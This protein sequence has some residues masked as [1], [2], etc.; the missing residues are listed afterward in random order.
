MPK[1][2]TFTNEGENSDSFRNLHFITLE[3]DHFLALIYVDIPNVTNIVLPDWDYRFI[4]IT[5]NSRFFS[6]LLTNRHWRSVR[7][8]LITSFFQTQ[9]HDKLK[10]SVPIFTHHPPHIPALL[11]QIVGILLPTLFRTLATN[12][13][14]QNAMKYL[15]VTGGVVSGLGKGISI[16]SLGVLLQ[17][18]G[19]KV[20]SIKIDPYLVCSPSWSHCHRTVM[21]VR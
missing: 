18:R 1:L 17:S 4:H 3:S 19:I 2:T 10:H 7:L 15:I 21:R 20:T 6:P 12:N 14:Y 11:S 9:L 8:L 16:S 5:T 13:S